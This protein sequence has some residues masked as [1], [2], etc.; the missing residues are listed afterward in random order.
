MVVATLRAVRIVVSGVITPGV[1]TPG[2]IGPGIITPGVTI[3][4]IVF[5]TRA[6]ATGARINAGARSARPWLA[7]PLGGLRLL[8][9]EALALADRAVTLPAETF[10]V[11]AQPITVGAETV[12]L[13]A[14]MVVRTGLLVELVPQGRVLVY[15]EL[16]LFEVPQVLATGVVALPPEPRILLS[17]SLEL[18]LLRLLGAGFGMIAG[19]AHYLIRVLKL[20]GCGAVPTGEMEGSP[21][22]V[23]VSLHIHAG[24]LPNIP[25]FAM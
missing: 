19:V 22:Y 5:F 16:E 7:G 20:I 6:V 12:T 24:L 21:S 13:A 15:L 14:E 4:G 3:S 23:T 11:T 8:E 25:C 10:A 2:V 18:V 9:A 17:Q 1:V